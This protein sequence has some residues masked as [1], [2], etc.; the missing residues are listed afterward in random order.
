MQSENEVRPAKISDTFLL[1]NFI[2][3]TFEKA[4][5]STFRRQRDCVIISC[6]FSLPNILD[7]IM[8]SIIAGRTSF[9]ELKND[10]QILFSEVEMRKSS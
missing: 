2:S 8:D 4:L 7:G 10:A 9:P 3:Q 1:N 5:F 6:G